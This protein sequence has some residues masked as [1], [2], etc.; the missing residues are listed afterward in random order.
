MSDAL[1]PAVAAVRR[2]VRL[3]LSDLEPGAHVLVACS[4][5]ADSMALA[6]AA[7]FEGTH[8]GWV[9]GAVVV[10]HGL[11]PGSATVSREV[12]GRL[13]TLGCAPVTVLEVRVGLDGGPE[14]AARQARFAALEEAGAAENA[15]VL[16]G[17]TLDDQAETVLLGLARGSGTRSLSGMAVVNGRF[18]RPLL[19]VR[20][21]QTVQACA[22][23]ALTVW[24]DPHNDDSGFARVRVRHEVLPR[25]E[26]ALG[27]GVTEALARTAAAARLDADLLDEQA[28]RVLETATGP[29]G[30]LDLAELADVPPALRR[31][32]LRRAAL[33]AGCPNGDLFAVHVDELD[34]LVHDWR[35][36]G[37]LTLPGGVLAARAQGTITFT[38][39]PVGR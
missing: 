17:H 26:E 16:L 14:A 31:R 1:D 10:D 3:T 5:G 38:R 37:P 25:L 30:A 27:P 24:H 8:A 18:R 28:D 39:T 6:D 12:A 11:Q 13:A 21:T 33:A 22:A 2:A 32:V 34:R 23:R 19:G 35:G 7:V 29:A 9:V 20:R 4:G 36:Q 15:T